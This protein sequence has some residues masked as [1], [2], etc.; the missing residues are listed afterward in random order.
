M[1]DAIKTYDVAAIRALQ[2]DATVWLLT[3]TATKR[4]DAS[5]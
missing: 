2:R 3:I 1:P 4:G 5:A